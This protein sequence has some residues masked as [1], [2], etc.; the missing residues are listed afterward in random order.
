MDRA[1]LSSLEW[2]AGGE[3]GLGELSFQRLQSKCTVSLDPA[4]CMV[5]YLEFYFM[6]LGILPTCL[7]VCLSV[8]LS[9]ALEAVVSSCVDAGNQMC[10][11]WKSSNC[12]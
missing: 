7:S 8:C 4:I 3:G 9:G 11:L 6:C 2:E 1:W 10:V 12:F 5:F